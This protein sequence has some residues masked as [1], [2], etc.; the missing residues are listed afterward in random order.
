MSVPPAGTVTVWQMPA[1]PLTSGL[2]ILPRRAL[3]EP[4]WACTVETA[5]V[6]TLPHDV[7]DDR[8]PVS[9]PG[10]ATMFAEVVAAL[11]GKRE[12]SSTELVLLPLE[13]PLTNASST[14]VCRRPLINED[15]LLPG[16][17]GEARPS[18][19][20]NSWTL[21]PHYAKNFFRM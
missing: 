6:L 1:V 18:N 21:N 2:T 7:H 11:C 9:K 16:G 20:Y 15:S 13:Q 19:Q 14:T 3:Y 12:E 17:S 8:D 5:G 4:V 10:F